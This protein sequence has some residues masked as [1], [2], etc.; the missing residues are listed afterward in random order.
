MFNTKMAFFTAPI[1][2]FF[3]LTHRIPVELK[4]FRVFLLSHDIRID[5]ERFVELIPAAATD[6]SLFIAHTA[7]LNSR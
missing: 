2:C 6:T 3:L 1:L 4:V 7:F 5:L